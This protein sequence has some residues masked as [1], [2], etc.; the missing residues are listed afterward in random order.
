MGLLGG[1]LI[2][3]DYFLTTT[4]S[5]VTGFQY[6][7][8]IF[9]SGR[10][11]LLLVRGRG[12]LAALTSS[13][14][15]RTVALTGL[16]VLFVNLVVIGTAFYTMDESQWQR[17][18][19]SSATARRFQLTSCWLVFPPPG[20]HSPVSSISQLS[21]AM[22]FPPSHDPL[23]HGC[24]DRD[25]GD[26]RP[27]LTALSIGLLPE[28]LK[29]TES[30]GSFRI[31]FHRRRIGIKLGCSYGLQFTSLCA[32]TAII[33]CYHVFLALV[34]VILTEDSGRTA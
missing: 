4:I 22:R 25:Y 2:T 34:K 18:S 1:M 30:E 23:C 14:F 9:P 13:A 15:E 12:V 8:S 29:A 24:S 28:H 19:A 10:S 21:P 17:S 3:V 5:A 32:N 6:I 27:V 7:G 31:G 33:G 26:D 20:W 11:R 16:R